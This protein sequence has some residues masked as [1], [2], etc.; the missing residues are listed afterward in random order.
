MLKWKQKPPL[1]LMSYEQCTT[2]P[3]NC[4]LRGPLC[5]ALSSDGLGGELWATSDDLPYFQA[6]LHFLHWFWWL[7][8]I[9]IANSASLQEHTTSLISHSRG[10]STLT[11]AVEAM[12]R[13][14]I[15]D[16]A[17]VYT[18]GAVW[19]TCLPRIIM[20]HITI[21]QPHTR[22]LYTYRQLQLESKHIVWRRWDCMWIPTT[23]GVVCT[24]SCG[25]C[26]KTY[27]D[28]ATRT[29]AFT[30]RTYVH[31]LKLWTAILITATVTPPSS[32]AGTSK[33]NATLCSGMKPIHTCRHP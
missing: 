28:L 6:L 27:F 4:R 32:V 29:H 24:T 15:P 31:V 23:S 9:V 13:L 33:W 10:A 7:L 21:H 14:M 19:P 25:C 18:S 8:P 1:L 5:Y 20:L 11:H 26:R 12:T 22:W 2:Y 16:W 3:L 17:R 30:D